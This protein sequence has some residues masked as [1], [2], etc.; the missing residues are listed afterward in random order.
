MNSDVDAL[1]AATG[2]K[3]STFLM[4]LSQVVAGIIIAFIYSWK[5]TLVLLA[6]SPLIAI[7]GVVQSKLMAMSAV[8]QSQSYARATAHAVEVVSGIRVVASFVWENEAQQI[9]NDRLSEAFTSQKREIHLTAVGLGFSL[10]CVFS[11]YSL[12]FWYGAQLVADTPANG[13]ILL[14]DMLIV[15]FSVIMAAMGLGQAMGVL[16]DFAKGEL[17]MINLGFSNHD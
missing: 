13:G 9:F 8:T 10:F 17:K 15:F 5:L 2:T 6:I 3:V 11:V 4:N 12:G 1:E 16:P 14:G 7:A